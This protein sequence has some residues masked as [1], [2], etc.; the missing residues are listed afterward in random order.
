SSLSRREKSTQAFLS[1]FEKL[2]QMQ[3]SS[4]KRFKLNSDDFFPCLN[5]NTTNTYFDR[6]YVYHPAWAARIVAKNRPEK[7]VDISSTLHFCSILSAFVPVDFYDYRP[8][9]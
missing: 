7:H 8:A 5:D 6:H 1:D 2:L 9:S 3:R 4:T